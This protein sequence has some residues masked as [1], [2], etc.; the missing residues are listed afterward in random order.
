MLVSS[1]PVFLDTYTLPMSSLGCK[2]LCIVISFFVLWTIC[3]SSSLVPFKNGSK[4]LTRETVHMFISLIRFPKQ[5]LFLRIVFY[6]LRYSFYF[7]F[8]LSFTVREGM[9]IYIL[10][11]YEFFCLFWFMFFSHIDSTL[12]RR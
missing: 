9:I 10:C 1:L 6:I 12:L 3:Q 11:N 4:Y 2:T 7:C 5:S 8:L